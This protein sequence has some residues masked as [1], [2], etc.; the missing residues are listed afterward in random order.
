MKVGRSVLFLCLFAVTVGRACSCPADVHTDTE[1]CG[2]APAAEGPPPLG[3]GEPCSDNTSCAGELVCCLVRAEDAGP[4]SSQPVCALNT[5]CVWDAVEGEP[6]LTGPNTCGH[7]LIC[8]IEHGQQPGVGVCRSCS[9][10]CTNI[11]GEGCPRDKYCECCK[12][13][14]KCINID[15]TG[16]YCSHVAGDSAVTDLPTDAGSDVIRDASND[17]DAAQ[18]TDQSPVDLASGPSDAATGAY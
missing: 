15:W 4:L 7:A 3:P 14:E 8:S 12:A 16:G 17:A 9:F 5:T 6:C 13:G 10:L 18:N 11:F 1:G 2:P